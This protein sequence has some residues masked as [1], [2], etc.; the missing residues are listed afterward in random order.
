M[1]RRKKKEPEGVPKFRNK[2]ETKGKLKFGNLDQHRAVM[3]LENP[4]WIISVPR[5]NLDPKLFPEDF[6]LS[7]YEV[8]GDYSFVVTIKEK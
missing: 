6:M 8:T 7:K 5:V 2:I 1:P 4:E 3:E